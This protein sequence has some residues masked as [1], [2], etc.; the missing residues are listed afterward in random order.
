MRR[1]ALPLFGIVCLLSACPTGES[2]DGR[3]TTF[4]TTMSSAGDG[5]GDGDGGETGA[6]GVGDGD[7]DDASCTPAC[8]IASCGDGYHYS[9][10][11]ACDDG[12]P[13]NTDDC[14]TGCKLATCG[15]G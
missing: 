3:F 8:Q 11:E 1:L 14:V 2:D 7:G 6:D 4:T 5:D 13:D 10:V 12:N 9:Q 15:D